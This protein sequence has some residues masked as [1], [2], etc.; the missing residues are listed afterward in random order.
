MPQ[1]A[2]GSTR[3]FARRLAIGLPVITTSSAGASSYISGSG[4][5]IVTGVGDSDA[6]AASILQVCASRTSCLQYWKAD[7]SEHRILLHPNTTTVKFT[8]LYN[9]F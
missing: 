4:C 2:M 1:W 6:L 8:L 7:W 3:V 5:G 9:N